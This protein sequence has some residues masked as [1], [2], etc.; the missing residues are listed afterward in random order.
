MFV[1]RLA[2]YIVSVSHKKL[3]T[4]KAAV[5]ADKIY[6][7]MCSAVHVHFTLYIEKNIQS[8]CN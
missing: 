4:L 2:G 7:Y 6:A 8:V 1:T 3:Y 5:N